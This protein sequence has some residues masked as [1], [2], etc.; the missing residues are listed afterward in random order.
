MREQ[1]CQ[2]HSTPRI[3]AMAAPT[4]P[5]AA[6][7]P[8]AQGGAPHKGRFT[9]P[10]LYS[11]LVA[12][13][14][15][16]QDMQDNMNLDP[17]HSHFPKRF[18]MDRAFLERQA[19]AKK[20][21]SPTCHFCRNP[22]VFLTCAK[23]ASNTTQTIFLPGGLLCTTDVCGPRKVGGVALRRVVCLQPDCLNKAARGL[24][25]VTYK[26]FV[27]ESVVAGSGHVTVQV[28]DFSCGCCGGCTAPCSRVKEKA[29]MYKR[30]KEAPRGQGAVKKP[31]SKSA[32]KTGANQ[33]GDPTPIVP[34]TKD[35]FDEAV[36]T[37]VKCHRES[38]EPHVS[39]EE[40]SETSFL[41]AKLRDA[42]TIL[43]FQATQT[44]APNVIQIVAGSLDNPW[45]CS[46]HTDIEECYC[47]QALKEIK[48]G[49]F[50]DI[51]QPTRRRDEVDDDD[52]ERV[53]I[54]AH[55]GEGGLFA[56][57]QYKDRHS[58]V[59]VIKPSAAAAASCLACGNNAK[60]CQHASWTN[61]FISINLGTP[62]HITHNTQSKHT[63]TH[64]HKTHTPSLAA[65]LASAANICTH[66]TH[67]THTHTLT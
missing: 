57:L 40:I 2:F 18:V 25:P 11:Q 49:A 5:A 58:W 65:G 47:L 35:N 45:R 7:A 43:P 60:G 24:V 53:Q 27:E 54:I 36:K 19:K 67:N 44:C 38:G 42:R 3:M 66:I 50:M 34:I 41:V 63:H 13:E 48:G 14:T 28:A 22:I 17:L 26:N 4:A 61:K 33:R 52:A 29:Q 21:Y 10:D 39:I 9:E 1:A 51:N 31:R 32:S 16:T 37:L 15:W 64:H 46:Q 55:K 12:A 30:K 23:N 62:Q 59:L 20:L 56:V 6:H 8:D